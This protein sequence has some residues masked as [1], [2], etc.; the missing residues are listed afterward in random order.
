MLIRNSDESAPQPTYPP[1]N[2][3]IAQARGGNP[4]AQQAAPA[5]AAYGQQPQQYD[6]GNPYSNQQQYGQQQGYAQSGAPGGQDFWSELNQTNGSLGE[7][8]EMIQAV[9]AAHQQSLVCFAL[10]D[11]G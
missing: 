9:R 3:V 6:A 10:G 7:L 5:P 2:G 4:Y 8:Q 11:I 1:S